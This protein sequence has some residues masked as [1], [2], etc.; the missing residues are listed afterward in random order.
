MDADSTSRR[1]VSGLAKIGLILKNH[2]WRNA[3]ARRLTPTQAQ[4]L[5]ILA[6]R[7]QRGMRLSSLA[8]ELAITAA[9]ASDAVST[10][11]K[12]GLVRKARD[13][14][15]SRALAIALTAKGRREAG[16]TSDWPDYLLAAVDAL[17]PAERESF[18]LALVK[19]V[20][21]LQDQG[22][23]PLARMCLNC[24]FFEPNRYSDRERPHHCGFVNGPFG[25][26]QFR[27]DCPDFEPA[28]SPLQDVNW[29]ALSSHI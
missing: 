2:A 28:P 9:T 16:R 11:L 8:R 19:M 20:R 21:S 17:T 18:L 5:A 29:D 4:V 1:I 10:L 24:S 13:A 27:L 22:K 15:D 23:I 26:G 6:A 3:A 7:A 25:P 14:E 12:K